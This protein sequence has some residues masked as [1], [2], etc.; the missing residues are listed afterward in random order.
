R[1]LGREARRLARVLERLRAAVETAPRLGAGEERGGRARV[2]LVRGR[3]GPLGVLGLLRLEVRA[4]EDDAHL[5]VARGEVGR[6]RELGERRVELASRREHLA[7][8]ARRGR[9]PLGAELRDR[10]ALDE[11]RAPVL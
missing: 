7:A 6:A 4:G 8:E 9:L 10:L 5:G 2:D 11:R 1:V 3:R